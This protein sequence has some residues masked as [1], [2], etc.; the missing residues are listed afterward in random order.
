[1]K[2]ISV[3]FLILIFLF[4]LSSCGVYED[5]PGDGSSAKHTKA[6]A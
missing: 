3:V 5:C 6:N 2:K 4:A 1:M